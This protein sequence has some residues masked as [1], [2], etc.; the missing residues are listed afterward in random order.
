MDLYGGGGLLTDARDLGWFLRKLMN[1]EVFRNEGTL[2]AMTGE[3][4]THYRLGLFCADLGGHLAWGHTGFW[5]TFAFHVPGLDLTVSGAVLDHFAAK[6]QTLAAQLVS[7]VAD[8][9]AR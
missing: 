6:G 3:G 5:N 4:T 9:S 2:A 8:R 1:G 7:T